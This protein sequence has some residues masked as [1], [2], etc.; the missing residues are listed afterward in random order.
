M[1]CRLAVFLTGTAVSKNRIASN[2]SAGFLILIPTTS[3][4]KHGTESLGKEKN[5]VVHNKV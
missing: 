1:D 4:I 3:H 5:S 2:L